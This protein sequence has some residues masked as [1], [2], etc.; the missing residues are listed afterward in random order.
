MEKELLEK[1][2]NMIE[3]LAVIELHTGKSESVLIDKNT[4][5]DIKKELHKNSKRLNQLESNLKRW[6]I[7]L[8][9]DGNNSKAIVRD[10]IKAVL[11]EKENAKS[12]L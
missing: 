12:K 1:I 6:F 3:R 11:E 2:D 8:G 7:L 10:E 9:K 5:L 4:L